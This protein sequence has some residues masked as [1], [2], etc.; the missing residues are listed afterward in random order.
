MIPVSNYEQR[1]SITNDDICLDIQ[2][3]GDDSSVTTSSLCSSFDFTINN[4]ETVRDCVVGANSEL[5]SSSSHHSALMVGQWRV[6]EED[7]SELPEIYPRLSS[8]LIIQNQEVS[9]I[10]DRLWAFLRTTDVRSAYDRDQGRVLCCNER[11]SFVVHFWRRKT[12]NKNNT[13]YF[14]TDP[15]HNET[16]STASKNSEEEIILE[17]QRR[18]GCGWAMHKIRSALKK[19]ILRQKQQ[20]PNHPSAFSMPS[21][22][23]RQ[24]RSIS[25][26]GIGLPHNGPRF[27]SS[28][29]ILPRNGPRSVSS[30]PILPI[31]LKGSF[32]ESVDKPISSLKN[33]KFSFG[34]PPL[35]P[36]FGVCPKP[37]WRRS[38]PPSTF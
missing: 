26:N 38:E 30:A 37:H 18:Q 34:M 23:P 28:T 14:P 29:P 22:L 33:V 2:S 6:R 32:E 15:D 9:E 25:E 36:T 17:I 1:H 11:V 19:A 5:L 21:P 13:L 10:G 7:V 16:A 27:V 8:P 3:I 24:K 31:H 20:R 12:Q 35:R 4:N